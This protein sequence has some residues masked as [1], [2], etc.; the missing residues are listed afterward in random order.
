ML[1]VSEPPGPGWQMRDCRFWT[2]FVR[3]TPGQP[4]Y[5]HYAVLPFPRLWGHDAAF[6]DGHAWVMPRARRSD[7][8]RHAAARFLRFL[9]AHNFAWTRTGHLPAFRRVLAMP[10]TVR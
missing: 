3:A 7:G 1:S 2:N 9:A 8:E 4:L 5:H 6:V 10:Q